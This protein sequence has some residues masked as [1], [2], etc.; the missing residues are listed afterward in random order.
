MEFESDG[1]FRRN[2]YNKR[3]DYNFPIVNFPYICSNNGNI[4]ETP[5]FG[6]YIHQLIRYSIG[7]VSYQ[8]F[9]DIRL[10]LMRKL[11]VNLRS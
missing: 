3:D 6:E 1:L 9:L 5:A 8:D 4:P 10:L 2:I 11:V 7:C